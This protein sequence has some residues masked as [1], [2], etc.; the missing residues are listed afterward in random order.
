M[1]LGASNSFVEL[2]TASTG[3][4]KPPLFATFVVS[5]IALFGFGTFG[6]RCDAGGWDLVVFVLS[7]VDVLFPDGEVL[8]EEELFEVVEVDFAGDTV[9]FGLLLFNPAL[10]ELLLEEELVFLEVLS[11]DEGTSITLCNVVLYTFVIFTPP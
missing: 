11:F 4:F 5:A 1:L 2:F 10:L 9:T 7:L 6:G 8:G 3:A